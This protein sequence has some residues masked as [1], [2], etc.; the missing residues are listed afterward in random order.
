M[1]DDFS[2]FVRDGEETFVI[3]NRFY[4]LSKNPPL[5]FLMD[6]IKLD[7]ITTK[8]K[9]KIHACLA[10]YF[11]F[12]RYF[13]KYHCIQISRTSFNLT[14]QKKIFCH[15]ISFVNRQWIPQPLNDQNL[16]SKISI[17][18]WCSLSTLSILIKFFFLSVTIILLLKLFLLIQLILAR[19]SPYLGSVNKNLRKQKSHT[20]RFWSLREW[21]GGLNGSVD[22]SHC[23]QFVEK[24]LRD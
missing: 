13:N 24:Y 2:N 18:C 16:L 22:Q 12:W 1:L 9:W 10:F 4:P 14:V 17:F 7:K 3:L 11:K 6:N 19:N 8:I 23:F 5:L 20:S 15:I 21:G